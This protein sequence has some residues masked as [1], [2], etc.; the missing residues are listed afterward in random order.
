[1]KKAAGGFILTNRYATRSISDRVEIR[2]G[3]LAGTA[4]AMDKCT[5]GQIGQWDSPVCP[6]GW[7]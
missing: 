5:A 6:N 1:M 4:T 2:S 3:S 7:Q